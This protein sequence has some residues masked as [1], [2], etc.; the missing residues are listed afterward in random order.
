MGNYVL[1]SLNKYVGIHVSVPCDF[2]SFFD[3][4]KQ[5]CLTVFGYFFFLSP[6]CTK[7]FGKVWLG[8]EATVCSQFLINF[9]S[10]YIPLMKRD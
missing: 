5:M 10:Q 7:Q 9:Q 8:L 1:K 6:S 3:L 4:V 2:K